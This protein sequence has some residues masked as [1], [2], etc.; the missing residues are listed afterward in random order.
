MGKEKATKILILGG[1]KSGKSRFALELGASFS[2]PRLFLATAE[3]FDEEMAR[4]IAC[5]RQE[6]DESWVTL[7][8]PLE[9]PKTLKDLPP[10]GVCLIDCL[11][12]WLGNLWYYRKERE[13]YCK[14]LLK[15]IEEIEIPLIIVSNEVGLGVMP[16]E[17]NTKSFA[18]ELGLLNQKVAALCDKIYFI[19]AGKALVLK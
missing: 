17:R 6:R 14:D 19:V 13:K 5:H 1:I 3:P 10:A 18:E 12:V 8:V 15:S 7:E 16:G 4:K 11:T 2:Q 9:I